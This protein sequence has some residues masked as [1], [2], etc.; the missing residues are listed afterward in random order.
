MVRT[1]RISLVA[2]VMIVATAC[3]GGYKGLSKPDFVARA[4]SVCKDYEAQLGSLISH[5]PG[6]P[7]LTEIRTVYVNQLIPLFRKEVVALRALD[8]PK[9]DR[10]TT[11]QIFDTLSG[12]VDQLESAVRGAKTLRE[13]EGVAPSGL[14]RASAAAKVYGMKV[15]GTS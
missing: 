14:T 5:V 4:D 9:A 3:G 7:T 15:C 12:G 2:A 8:P 6:N 11:K 10:A 13:L 1:V